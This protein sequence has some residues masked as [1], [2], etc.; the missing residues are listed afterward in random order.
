MV[1][2]PKYIE[3]QG[4][5]AT[6]HD[7]VKRIGILL[8]MGEEVKNFD[9]DEALQ[10][11]KEIVTRSQNIAYMMG[12][13]FGLCLKG[14]CNRLKGEYNTGIEVL[15]EAL[16]LAKRIQD[17]NIEATAYCYLGN[18]YREMGDLANVML[19]YD[20]ALVINQEMGD[21]Y[22]QSVILSSISNLLFD[23]N[24]YDRALEYALKCL[25]IFERVNNINSL[26]NIHNTLGN[27]YFKK[28]MFVESLHSF[29]EN[30]KRSEPETAAYATAESGLGKVYYKMHEFKY[31]KHC[32]TNALQ[33]SKD[34]GNAEV[35]T[36]CNYYLGSLHMDEGN[37]EMS[38]EYFN[39]AKAIAEEYNR[40]HDLM[41][42]Y[43]KLSDIH[44]KI[45]DIHK[46][47][48]YIKAYEK[49]KDEIF[50]QNVF[51]KVNNLEV[52]QQIELAKKEKEVAER[53]AQ[54]KHKFM[55]NMSH[56]IRTPMNAIVGMTR[57]ILSKDPKPEHLRYL[58]AIRMS[59]DNLLVI[60]NDI[61]DFS[62]IEAGK[63]TIEQIDFNLREVM[64]GIYDMLYTKVEEKGIGFN[65]EI[66][67]AIPQ[68]IKGDPTK[69]NQILI[70]LTGNAIKFTSEGKVEII[71]VLQKID[72]EK[73]VIRF[74]VKDT[75]IGISQEYI[76]T[77]FDSFTQAGS[78]ITRKFGGTGLGLSISK[79][80]TTLMGG[81]IIVTSELGKGSTFAAIVVF[82]KSDVQH[83]VKKAET[84][85]ET[86]MARLKRLKIMVVEDNEFNRMVAEDTLNEILPGIEIHMAVHGQEAVDRLK[87]EKFDIVLMDIQMPVMDG[88]TA[89]KTIRKELTGPMQKVKIIAM[90]ANVM[91]EDIKS[92]LEIGMDSYVCK[93]FHPQELLLRMNEVTTNL[94]ELCRDNDTPQPTNEQAATITTAATAE[95]TPTEALPS[96]VTD[97]KFIRQFTGG[98]PD[99]LK[100]YLN[101]FLENAPQLLNQLENGI[102]AKDHGKIKIAAHSFKPQLTY[103]G[104]KEEISKIALIEHS[105]DLKA[106]INDIAALFA[107]LKI[108]CSKAFEEVSASN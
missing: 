4:R 9:V 50:K 17:R 21:E 37:D 97:M 53:A 13:G 93:P 30:L 99:K 51:D 107:N 15:N 85:D 98:N 70:N 24:D 31:A 95:A 57:L 7:E 28:D 90:T 67:P 38:L 23:L 56:E 55:A 65:I 44:E 80:L 84:L 8:S 104:V 92:Y 101:M 75:G 40:R 6:E 77:I 22:Y 18:I 66:D 69:L 60:I 43:E 87:N 64:Q 47:F 68:M 14:F 59:A 105:A 83:E 10:I 49:L 2:S 76:G 16:T 3:L 52:R 108:V 106:D 5:L 35:Q 12:L 71:A 63:I 100:K 88:I 26:L 89:T 82:E 29:K 103:M 94:T 1:H 86:L 74:D 25:P 46:A 79:Q 62:K 32:L 20:K 73:L 11:A 96:Q 72:E 27:I 19:L 81:D 54:L 91:Q 45:G 41:F 78:D 42:I 58:N 61:L 39:A 34:L 36:I 48:H 33:K 102:A